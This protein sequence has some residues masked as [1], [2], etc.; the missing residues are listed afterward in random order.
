M[1]IVL[2]TSKLSAHAIATVLDLHELHAE[3]D[4]RHV[5]VVVGTTTTAMIVVA[6]ATTTPTIVVAHHLVMPILMAVAVVA[7]MMTE[8]VA[9]AVLPAEAHHPDA[10]MHM[11]HPVVGMRNHM[12]HREGM[13]ALKI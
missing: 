3:E 12:V 11:V 6:L 7:D 2:L 13:I 4:I 1:F 9:M 10:M 5:P 8:I